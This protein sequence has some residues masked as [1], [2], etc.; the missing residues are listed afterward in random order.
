MAPRPTKQYS[1]SLTT[2]HYHTTWHVAAISYLAL[3]NSTHNQT[4]QHKRVTNQPEAMNWR[5]SSMTSPRNMKYV[6][7]YKSEEK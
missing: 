2:G 3:H 4:A 5:Q 1:S 7:V 6:S